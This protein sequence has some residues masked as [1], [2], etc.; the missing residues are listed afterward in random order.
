MASG[1]RSGSPEI[2][3]EHGEPSLDETE[4]HT[5]HEGRIYRSPI[6]RV[7]VAENGRGGRGHRVIPASFQG[8]PIRRGKLD[9]VAHHNATKNQTAAAPMIR[10][11]RTAEAMRSQRVGIGLGRVT[12]GT[13]RL[14]LT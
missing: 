13:T 9:L 4:S 8:L 5:D 10:K 1:A 6:E 7:R 11:A 2:E 14:G 3:A 12:P